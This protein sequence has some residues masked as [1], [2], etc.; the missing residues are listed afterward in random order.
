MMTFEEFIL[1][2]RN[3]GAS[4]IHLSVDREPVFRVNGDLKKLEGLSDIPV[5]KRLLISLLSAEQEE[6]FNL[7]NDIDFVFELKDGSRQ[8]ANLYRQMGKLACAIRLLNREVPTLQ[9]M[10]LPPLLAE[11][12]LKRSGLVLCTGVTGSG[13][14]TTLSIMINHINKN[15]PCHIITLEDPVEYRYKSD[16][17]TIHQR[18]IGRDVKNFDAALRSAL[19]EDPDVIFVGEMRDYET[20]QLAITAAETGHLVL[21]TLHTRGAIHT[22]NRIV[23]ACPPHIQKQVL[24]QLSQ[25]LECVISQSLLPKREG[26]GRI[27]VLEIL[28]GTDAVKNMIRQEKTFQLESV[29]Q[30]NR[31]IGMCLMDDIILDYYLKNI[32]SRESALH[33]STDRL[34]MENRIKKMR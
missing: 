15:R 14:T 16:L 34:E 17:A 27:A 22:I 10:G 18:E 11:I 20:I 2:A 1:G 5:T 32:I 4:D 26:K 24:V 3:A 25:I 6:Q 8:R 21:A 12:S 9:E 31:A 30:Q 28:L 33:Y 7:G 19:R 23:D 13:K 29:M